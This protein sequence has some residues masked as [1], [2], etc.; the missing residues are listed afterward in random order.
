MSFLK[1]PFQL[2]NAIIIAE[3]NNPIEKCTVLCLP[4]LGIVIPIFWLTN[5]PTTIK[6]VAIDT[7]SPLRVDASR[8][9][10]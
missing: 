9:I 8:D 6:N 10:H 2:R 3:V 4:I 1:S 7:L 5:T